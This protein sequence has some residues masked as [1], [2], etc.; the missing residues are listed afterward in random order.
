[1]SDEDA[2]LD[3]ADEYRQVMGHFLTGVTVV[4]GVREDVPLGFTCQSFAS[5]SLHPRLVTI[6]PS[7]FSTSWPGIAESGLFC[8]NI[9]AADQAQLA[10]DFAVSGGPKFE[11]VAW[12]PTKAGNPRIDGHLAFVDCAIAA[13][14]EAG[15]HFIVVGEVLEVGL[16]P[17]PASRPLHYFR[18]RLSEPGRM[19]DL[20]AVEITDTT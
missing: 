15:D 1:V 11:G 10:R 13:I 18:G 16:G 6:V 17:D 5:V 9:L 3:L 2:T 8:V 20:M 19:L 7:L 14:H 4:T 12:S